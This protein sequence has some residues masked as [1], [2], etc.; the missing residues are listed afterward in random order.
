MEMEGLALLSQIRVYYV[1]Y[2]FYFWIY[3]L[4]RLHVGC[5]GNS[6]IVFVEAAHGFLLIETL[7]LG[8]LL[9][10]DVEMLFRE[11]LPCVLR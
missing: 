7:L 9:K 8:T 5:F 3:M 10:E 1:L 6:S 11:E 2:L 4:T